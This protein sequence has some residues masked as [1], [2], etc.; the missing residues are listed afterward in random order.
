M[1][2][3]VVV[4]VYNV[5]PHLARCLESLLAQTLREIE[6]ICVDDG[7]TDGSA[8]ILADCASRDGRLRVIRQENAGAGAARNRGLAEA[9]GEYLF[10][11]DPDDDCRRGMLAGL[12]ARAKE[13]DA[14]IVIAG[15]EVVDG[16]T[17]R[18]NGCFGFNRAV[19]R[20]AQPFAGAEIADFIFMLA[21]SVVWDKLF[22]RAFVER[23]GLLFQE[24]RRSNDVRF[25]DLAL[26][27]A[28][29]IAL[30]PR[31]YYRYVVR[32]QGSLQTTRESTALLFFEAYGSLRAELER[33][34]LFE[35]FARGYFYVLFRTALFNLMVY[36]EPANVKTCYAKLREAMASLDPVYREARSPFLSKKLRR[37]YELMRQT[38]DAE[39]FM[40][41]FLAVRAPRH[42]IAAAADGLKHAFRLAVRHLMPLP[43]KE[44]CKRILVR[45][46]SPASDLEVGGDAI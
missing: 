30:L 46:C 37:L 5:A 7:S 14:D 25:V 22:R 18:S 16:E 17:G 44:A 2:V 15:K 42:G 39:T 32:R 45:F 9:T 31:A 43:L 20:H 21:K 34:G 4:P 12:Y 10:F 41:G 35:T 27:H 6:V 26:A 29:R 1:K 24:I 23:H 3:S 8:D 33:A 11:C 28:E 13:T 38:E 19:Y 36:R 40:R